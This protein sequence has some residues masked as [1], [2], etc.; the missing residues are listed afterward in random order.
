MTNIRRHLLIPSERTLNQPLL[1]VRVIE[2]FG[3]VYKRV[4]KQAIDGYVAFRSKSVI[5]GSAKSRV[6]ILDY[7]CAGQPLINLHSATLMP[8]ATDAN[9]AVRDLKSYVDQ[10]DSQH[11]NSQ[12]H[13]AE[14]QTEQQRYGGQHEALIPR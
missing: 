8:I 2:D 6:S 1:S 4:C 7:H 9:R 11:G 3:P 13:E 12:R 5:W 14:D 10:S